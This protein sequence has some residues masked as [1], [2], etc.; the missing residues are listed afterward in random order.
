M[1][2]NSAT[3]AGRA[4]TGEQIER[5]TDGTTSSTDE[6]IATGRAGS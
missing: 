1:D 4:G 6:R 5:A 3:A 2:V